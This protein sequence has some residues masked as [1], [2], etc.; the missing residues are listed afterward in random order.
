M[1]TETTK[2]ADLLP[3]IVASKAGETAL[4]EQRFDGWS[5][6]RLANL[7]A[8]IDDQTI[9]EL[10]AICSCPTP[11]AEPAAPYYVDECV[12]TLLINLPKRAHG[13]DDGE[14]LN[15]TYSAALKHYSARSLKF[16]AKRALAKCKWFPTIA[17][18]IEIIGEYRGDGEAFGALK[19]GA[20]ARIRRELNMRMDEAVAALGRRELSQDAI[21]ALPDLTKRVA[22]EKGYLWKWPDGRFT[23]RLDLDRLDPEA[24]DAERARIKAMI[25]EWE[26]M[27][28]E[29]EAAE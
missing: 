22:A 20:E 25:A 8:R 16:L 15:R 12:T 26:A 5:L 7:P 17:E 23:V 13:E 29:S 1:E 6:T 3:G 11:R 27:T 9:S 19:V 10:R 21:D 18:C 2:M 4:S 14:I 28:A 24:R